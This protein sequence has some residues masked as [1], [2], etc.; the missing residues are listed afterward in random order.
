MR[1]KI[2]FGV[3]AALAACIL[4]GCGGVGGRTLN[5]GVKGDVA[6]FSLYDEESGRYSGMEIDLA[7]MLAEDLGYAD[8]AYVNVDSTTRET[9]IDSGELDLV[10]ATYS[11]TNDRKERYDFPPRTTRTTR[12]SWWR[13]PA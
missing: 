7:Q 3:L 6:N 12:R 10:I 11:I 2:H 1:E 8:V 4:T 9:M 5:V 13:N